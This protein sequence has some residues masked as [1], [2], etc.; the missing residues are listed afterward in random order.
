MA[1]NGEVIIEHM[2]HSVYLPDD[3]TETVG[4]LLKEVMCDITYLQQ[5]AITPDER[6]IAG[7]ISKRLQ[8][9][10]PFSLHVNRSLHEEMRAYLADKA[11]NQKPTSPQQYTD[12]SIIDKGVEIFAESFDVNKPTMAAMIQNGLVGHYFKKNEKYQGYFDLFD[13]YYYMKTQE[14][15]ILKALSGIGFK[16]ASIEYSLN[17]NRYNG[18]KYSWIIKASK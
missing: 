10:D 6:K 3:Y 15:S 16:N 12:Y 8:K 13:V 18:R 4:K 1:V 14:S 2:P 9:A 11:K 7:I 17:P 5:L